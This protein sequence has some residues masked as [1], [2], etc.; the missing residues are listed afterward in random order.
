MGNSCNGDIH[1]MDYKS[2]K[3]KKGLLARDYVI[4]LII[5]S[6]IIA[7]SA[8]LVANM[9]SPGEG[10]NTPDIID[11]DFAE[12]YSNLEDLTDDINTAG[13]QTRGGL[14]KLLGSVGTFFSSTVTVFD[15]VFGSFSLINTMFANFI[16]DFGV[17]SSV[18]NIIFPAILGIITTIIIFVVISSLT[19]SKV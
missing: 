10:Y 18:A 2:L 9:A 19:Q 13:N 4:I 14:S 1:T 8:V 17:P 5:F 16:E 12:R 7:L 3:N 15:I 6:A 11:S